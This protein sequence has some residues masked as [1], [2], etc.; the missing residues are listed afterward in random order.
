MVAPGG[1]V[2]TYQGN[3]G[4][5]ISGGQYEATGKEEHAVGDGILYSGGR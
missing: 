2:D 4:G 1:S 3:L 5:N